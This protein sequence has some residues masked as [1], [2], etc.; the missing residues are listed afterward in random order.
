[1]NNIMSLSITMRRVPVPWSPKRQLTRPS[2]VCRSLRGRYPLEP[3]DMRGV[4]DW[5]LAEGAGRPGADVARA[6]RE[7]M[8]R[9]ADQPTPRPE[10]WGLHG[11]ETGEGERGIRGGG[12]GV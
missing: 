8:A 9:L 12:D 4:R 6:L 11:A 3:L 1:M 10:Y 5:L 2:C 7:V